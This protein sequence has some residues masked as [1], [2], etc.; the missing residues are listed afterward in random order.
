MEPVSGAEPFGA[1][2]WGEHLGAMG[3]TWR[4]KDYVLLADHFRLDRLRGDLLDVGCAVGDGF[5]VIRAA[6]AQITSYAGCDFSPE[7]VATVARRFGDVET[8][9]HD[10][11]QPLPR[12]WDTIV[13]LQT[14]EHVEDP[15]LA[16]SHLAAAARRTLIVATP[17]R[18]RRPDTDHRWSFDE[19][20][21]TDVFDG[22]LLDR[23][24]R[25]IFWY[26]SIDGPI[27]RSAL[28]ARLLQ[29]RRSIERRLKRGT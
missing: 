22:W 1:T 26:R 4:D 13:C 27:E 15:V 24:Q 7:G 29:V 12:S 20:D 16:V 19:H 23:P 11:H 3:E 17:Y 21:F 2:K 10:V 5:P 14:I 28:S 6:A 25:N 18:N 9:V 8:F